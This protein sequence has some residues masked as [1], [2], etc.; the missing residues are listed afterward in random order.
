MRIVVIVWAWLTGA[1]AGYSLRPPKII[2]QHIKVICIPD[3]DTE[4]KPG[5]SI[6]I[7]VEEYKTFK[8][9][10]KTEEI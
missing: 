3:K 7:S 10:V 6:M 9:K 1:Y 4:A 8:K 5:D 2:E